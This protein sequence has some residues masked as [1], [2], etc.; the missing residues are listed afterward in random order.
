M[1]GRVLILDT[2]VLCCLLEIPGKETA[3]SGDEQWDH[4]KISALLDSEV[5]AT[6]VLPLATVIETGNHIAQSSGDRYQIAKALGELISSAAEAASP[7][8]AFA[9]QAELWGSA[10]L[11]SLANEWP[12]LATGGTS[13]GDATIKLVAEY[14]ARAGYE[15]EIVTGDAGLKAYQPMVPPRTPRRRS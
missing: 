11:V 7:W 10:N 15:V 8:A 14:Y 9:D 4:N 1:A 13:I 2:S 3:G 6:R 5:G 12:H